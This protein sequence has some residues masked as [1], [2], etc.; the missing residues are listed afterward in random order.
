VDITETEKEYRIDVEIPAV[1]VKDVDVSVKDGVLTV[2]GERNAES[3]SSEGRRHRVERRWGKF[4][5]SFRLPENV[6]PESIQANARN[7]VLY[8]VIAKQEQAGPRRIE[9][10]AA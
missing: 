3:E 2:S 8:L 5:R 4:A 1:A 7:G 9:V 10:R 6:D